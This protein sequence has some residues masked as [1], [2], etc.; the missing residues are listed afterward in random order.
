M[1]SMASFPGSRLLVC[2]ACS[3]SADADGI[4]AGARP[5]R[6]AG[7][8]AAGHPHDA[9]AMRGDPADRLGPGQGPR[10]CIRYYLSTAGGEGARP[11]GVPPGRPARPAQ[12]ADR[13]IRARARTTRTSTP[14][15][16]CASPD[17]M[18]KQFKTAAIYLA[19]LGL[20]GSSGRPPHPPQRARAQR[21]QRGARRHQ[22][23]P[24]LRGLPPG[25][26]VRRLGAGRRHAGA[27]HR[28]RLRGDRL[29]PARANDRPPPRSHDPAATISTSPTRCR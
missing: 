4:A 10:F 8:H 26:P 22:A 9:G 16:S 15:T 19:R 23:P 17:S 2:L 20:D 24:R 11:V 27:A 12:P 1:F 3:G 14:T 5:Y 21:H 28:Y 7:R 18:S 29:R 6:S 25:R 13:R